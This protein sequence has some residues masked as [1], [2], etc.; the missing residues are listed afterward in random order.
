MLGRV[1]G[2]VEHRFVLHG[3]GRFDPAGGRHD[4]RRAGVIDA[5]GEFVR[6]EP[7]EHNRVHRAQP[8][9]R[10]HRDHGLGDHRH[11]HHHP[12]ALRHAQPAQHAGEPRRLVEQVA[13]GVGA[14]SAGDRRVIDQ[15]RLLP[16]AIGDVAVQRVGAGIQLPVGKPPVEGRIS[17]V[18]D[19][20]RLPGP[21]HRPRGIRPEGRRILDACVEQ[22]AISGHT[23]TVYGGPL[24]QA[25]QT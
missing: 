9:A 8:G 13:V 16:V 1:D 6:G 15:R 3:P 18:K 4:N 2:V 11:V 20:L 25:E 22:F 19:A 14:L 5:H 17:V 23:G 7:A 10:Q 12:V 21:G 24:P